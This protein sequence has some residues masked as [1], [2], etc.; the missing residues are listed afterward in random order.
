MK[1]HVPEKLG[2]RAAFTLIELL[3]VIG[4][5]AMLGTVSITSYFAAV[6]GMA[7]RAVREDTISLIRLA[8]TTCLIDQTPTAVLFYNQ[9]TQ[10][11]DREESEGTSAGAAVAIKMVGRISYVKGNVIVDE[12][13]DWNQSCPTVRASDNNSPSDKGVRF[14]HMSDISKMERGIDDCSSIVS[15][16]V[17]PVKFD[18]EYM[19]A[20]GRQVHSFCTTYKKNADDNEKFSGVDSEN[21]NNH[22]WGHRVKNAN[23]ITWKIGDAYGVEIGSLRLPKGFI[24]G[25]SSPKSMKIDGAPSIAFD[26]RDASGYADYEVGS[27]SPIKISSYRPNGSWKQIDP[28]TKDDLKDEKQR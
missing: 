12:F 10:T 22:R 7:N 6:R 4:L 8:R 17:E 27:F 24:Y 15:T 21:G 1:E 28:I 23:G 5:M 14:Y 20:S 18:D 13:A 9:W 11:G 26:P 3:V 25:T 2:C 16:A 19:I